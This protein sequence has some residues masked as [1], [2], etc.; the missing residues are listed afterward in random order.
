LRFRR[1][2]LHLRITH[3]PM[4]RLLAAL[5]SVALLAMTGAFSAPAVESVAC[6]ASPG[7]CCHEH[8]SGPKQA[9]PTAN[10]AQ[11]PLACCALLLPD[12]VFV[13]TPG[14]RIEQW[15]LAHE[16]AD[17]RAERPPVPPPRWS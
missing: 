17:I 5:L 1:G 6:A 15:T 13:T 14:S 12:E 11:C 8:E 2:V 10:C 7:G 4:K 16:H 3:Y 9:P